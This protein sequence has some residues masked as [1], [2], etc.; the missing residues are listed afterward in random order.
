MDF[1][2]DENKLLNYADDKSIAALELSGNLVLGRAQANIHERLNKDSSGFL[3]NTGS[4]KVFG[5]ARV[6]VSFNAEHAAIQELGGEIV[7]N[8]AQALAIPVHKDAK[9]KSPREFGDLV[10]IERDGHNP[11]LVRKVGKRSPKIE[12]MYVLTKSVHIDGTDYL[13]DAVYSNQNDLL[14]I[15]QSA[16]K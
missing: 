16:F 3:A 1:N 13:S 4:V 5:K 10:L 12:V 15:Y 7:P 11:I 6:R 8:E 14:R 2:F 9:G